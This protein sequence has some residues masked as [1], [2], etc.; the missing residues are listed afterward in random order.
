MGLAAPPRRGGRV[1]EPRLHGASWRRHGRMLCAD[2]AGAL[3]TRR[4]PAGG[5]CDHPGNG[6]PGG[7]VGTVRRWRLT[8]ARLFSLPHHINREK[9]MGAF[10]SSLSRTVTAGVG[11][12]K[13]REEGTHGFLPVY[14]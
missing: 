12:R 14:V 10:F 3:W 13:R 6:A 2:R 11:A 8:R 4:A 1:P 5:S 9:T 7:G